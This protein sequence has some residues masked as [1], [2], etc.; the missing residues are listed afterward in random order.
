MLS[1]WR[2][3]PQDSIYRLDSALD[4]PSYDS[5]RLITEARVLNI[6]HLGYFILRIL[7]CKS[8]LSSEQ[9]FLL[10]NYLIIASKVITLSK[11]YIG[12]L[13]EISLCDFVA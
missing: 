6:S 13:M 2:L 1:L 3:G 11:N 5:F 9:F 8:S 10:F 7:L 4:M 12:Y